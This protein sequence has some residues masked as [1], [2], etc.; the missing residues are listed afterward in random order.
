ME[1]TSS[2]TNSNVGPQV[3]FPSQ[4]DAGVRNELTIDGRTYHLSTDGVVEPTL[5]S[6]AAAQ[7]LEREEQAR[8]RI[9]LGSSHCR[10]YSGARAGS[11]QLAGF[12]ADFNES[13][14]DVQP[15]EFYRYQCSE[16]ETHGYI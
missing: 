13:S 9:T 10:Q 3:S 6:I 14:T 2:D 8:T 11:D 15:A 1:T 4:N 5:E 7:A 12:F 16:I